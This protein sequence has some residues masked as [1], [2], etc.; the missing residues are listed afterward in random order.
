MQNSFGV[1]N[2]KFVLFANSLSCLCAQNGIPAE[3]ISLEIRRVSLLSIFMFMVTIIL[4]KSRPHGIH[5]LGG[6]SS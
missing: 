6:H 5:P 4:T 3:I 2:Y 1:T